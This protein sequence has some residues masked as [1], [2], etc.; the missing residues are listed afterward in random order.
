MPSPSPWLWALLPLS[1]LLVVSVIL[2][3]LCYRRFSRDR[4]NLQIS[5]DRANLDLQMISHRIQIRVETQYEDSLPDSLPAKQPISLAK[6]PTASLPPG[7]PSSSAGQ[8]VAEQEV[9]FRS[10]TADSGVAST[11]PAHLPVLTVWPFPS[12]RHASSSAPRKRPAQPESAS[13]PRATKKAPASPFLEFCQ[14]QR[15]LLMPLG[16]ANRDREKLLGVL[17]P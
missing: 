9:T 13:A 15:P 10:G 12:L 14:E 6:A 17:A 8:S 4:A 7:P 16:M 3:V 5:R 11:A 1:V 2:F